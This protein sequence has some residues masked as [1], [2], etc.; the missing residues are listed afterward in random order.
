MHYTWLI[1]S[2]L[3]L[4]I[5]LIVYFSL[6]KEENRKEMLIVSLW[7]SLLGLTE[8][9][10]VPA[11]WNPP[12]L[13][14][15]ANKTGFDI[16]SFLFAFGVGGLAVVLYELIFKTDHKEIPVSERH[17]SRHG[18]HLPILLSAPVI[19]LFLLIFSDLNPIYSTFI[20]LIIGGLLTWYCRP[21]LK[22]KMIVSAFIFLAFYFIFFLTLIIIASPDYVSLVWNFATISG[23]LIFGIPL[24]ELMFA[25]GLGFFWSSIY[26]HIKWYKIS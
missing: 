12:S 15:L 21:D 5:W 9:I 19:F 3:L 13:F 4:V 14:D 20:S 6:K 2:L 1:W 23:I 18:Y 25:F 17:D 16:E 22:K 11:Y 26:E 10:F 7:T 8:P 24:E